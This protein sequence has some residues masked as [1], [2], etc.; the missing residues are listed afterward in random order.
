MLVAFMTEWHLVEGA[1]LVSRIEW[2]FSWDAV[3]L[4]DEFWGL[5]YLRG[6]IGVAGN[7]RNPLGWSVG[8]LFEWSYCD[9]FNAE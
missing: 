2:A 9:V 6:A 7:P 8:A 3:G 1:R 4:R 5:R